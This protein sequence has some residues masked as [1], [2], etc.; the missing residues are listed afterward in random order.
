MSEHPISTTYL[1]RQIARVSAVLAG[2][3]AFD[4]APLELACPEFHFV[5]LEIAYTRGGAGGDMQLKI[6]ISPDATGT[7]WYQAGLYKAGNVLSGADVTSNIQREEIEYGSTA[8]GVERFTLA[9]LQLQGGA[10]RIRI[11]CQE[12]GAVGT[13]GMVEIIAMFS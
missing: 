5:T 9:P 11:P 8:A 2:G 1:D 6:E 12:S 7:D 13:P 4:V 10:Q 3:G